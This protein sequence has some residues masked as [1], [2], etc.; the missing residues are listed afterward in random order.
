MADQPDE[1]DERNLSTDIR[2]VA[3]RKTDVLKKIDKH[4]PGFRQDVRDTICGFLRSVAT[5]SPEAESARK[6]LANLETIPAD[7]EAI[8]IKQWISARAFTGS[9]NGFFDV[10]DLITRL[11]QAG[12][13]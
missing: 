13:R 9:E 6:A 3:R 1:E 5:G 7:E 12:R 4:R 10:K 2:A 11:L 8:F